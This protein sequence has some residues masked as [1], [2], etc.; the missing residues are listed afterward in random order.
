MKEGERRSGQRRWIGENEKE[1]EKGG[2][3]ERE[4]DRT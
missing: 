2:R 3:G 1:K 4:G